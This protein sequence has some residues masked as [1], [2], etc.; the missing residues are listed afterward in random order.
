MSFVYNAKIKSPFYPQFVFESIISR[1]QIFKKIYQHLLGKTG[2]KCSF[3]NILFSRKMVHN[4][5][6]VVKKILISSI[7]AKSSIFDKF[8]DIWQ[9]M[10]HTPNFEG[11]FHSFDIDDCR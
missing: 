5:K 10:S 4:V 6:F 2:K 11:S 3:L 7:Y 1:K 8:R 9:N